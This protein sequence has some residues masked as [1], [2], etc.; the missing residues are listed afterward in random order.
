MT[1]QK[2]SMDQERKCIINLITSTRFCK[3]ILPLTRKQYWATNY[4][5]E[6]CSWIEEY[7]SQFSIAPGKDIKTI[8]QSKHASI[9]NEDIQDE[10][11]LFLSSIS[12]EYTEET[13]PNNPDYEIAQAEKYLKLRSLEI[14]KSSL[15]ES[16]LDNN[17]MKGEQ[18][19][20]NFKRVEKPL[21]QGISLLHDAQ[22]VSDAFTDEHDVMFAFPGALGK[23]AGKMCRGDFVSFFAPMK[24]G[25][26]WWLWYIAETALHFHHK[27]IF[28][29]LEM[30]SKQIIQRSWRSLI[31]QPKE[32]MTLQI[33]YFVK[34]DDTM[35]WLVE[36]KEEERE[37]I[38]PSQI[39]ELQKR[40]RRKFRKGDVRIISLPTK[41]ASVQDLT[42]HLDNMEHY[43]NF[44][45]DVIVVDYADILICNRGFK[46]EYRNQLDNI[47]SSLR[48]M[49]MERNC[50]VVTASQT[51]KGTFTKDV[52]AES[53]AED[54]RKMA[55]IT[56]GLGINQS[57][58]EAKRGIIR[59]SQIATREDRQ[60]FD[61]AI[62]LQCLDIGRPCI[63]SRLREE[64]T[65]GE[66]EEKDEKS[67]YN[68]KK[69]E[70]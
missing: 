1:I 69:N 2:I 15:E 64:V 35:K 56:C 52:Q 53:A 22:K 65:M 49:A 37:G 21:G 19:L 59:I 34:D 70:K 46:G 42:A 55:H 18:A 12:K 29:T 23:V 48:Q 36:Q 50:L 9:V 5:R 63:D 13:Q 30:T 66:H 60:C 27:V 4:A 40:F 45:P 11:A 28:F 43:E 7:Y 33:P 20:S 44:I 3:E 6:V 25:K 57:K 68:R 41:S 24:R 47:W 32:K 51:E 8:Y 38:D 16:I 61:Q 26:S 62:V 67:E 14:L 39:T 10:V 17:P 58:G 54:I 31:G